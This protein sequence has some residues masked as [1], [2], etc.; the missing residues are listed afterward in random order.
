MRAELV[1]VGTEL[2]LGQIANT[3][4]QWLSERLAEIGMDVL[5]HDVVGD[6]AERIDA[7]LREASARA[8]VVIVTG[9]LGPTDDDITR[10]RLAA[11][12]GVDLVRVP[13]IES[14]MR[15]RF[16]ALGRPMAES[17]LRQADVPRGAR[18][19]EARLG[20]A[21]GLVAEVSGCTVYALPGVPTEMRD[22]METT[23]LPELRA[24]VG[25][26]AIVSRVIRSTGIAE[27]RIGELLADLFRSSSNPTVAYLAGGGEVRVRLTARADDAADAAAL[28]APMA[29]EVTRR[30]GDAVISSEGEELEGVVV[31]LLRAAGR[32]LAGAES[33]TGGELGARI[34]SVPGAS[35]VFVGSAVC[36]SASAKCAILGVSEATIAGH[37]PVSRECAAEMA[38]GARARFGADIGLALTGVAGPGPLGGIEPGTVWIGIAT[39]DLAHERLL[40]APGERPAARRW[41]TQHGL[42]LVRRY[43]AGLPLP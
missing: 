38:A 8:D 43:L 5:R 19:I 7:M 6:N 39:P 4:A 29:E 42:D 21:P 28:L 30:L 23:V 41:A 2:L 15:A 25:V 14:A 36:Y 9:G 16:E 17:N 1:A 37:G 40:R 3:N 10:D 27:A 34:T 26:G 33:L 20:T 11:V 18:W 35:E 13:E 22:M 24:R 31:R 12:M 32:T